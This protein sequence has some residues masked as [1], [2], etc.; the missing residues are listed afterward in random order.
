MVQSSG[1]VHYE[2]TVDEYLQLSYP[3]VKVIDI[4][5]LEGEQDWLCS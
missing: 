2:V 5:A 3:V 4:E 1:Y